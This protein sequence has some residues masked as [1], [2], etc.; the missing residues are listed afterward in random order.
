MALLHLMMAMLLAA[1]PPTPADRYPPPGDCRDD[2][3]VDRCDEVQQAKVRDLFGLG[4]IEDHWRAGD[5]V[6]RAFY[7]DGYGRDVVAITFIRPRGRDPYLSVDF[8]LPNGGDRPAPLTSPLSERDWLAI[9]EASGHFHR[10]LAPLPQ[11]SSDEV[12]ICLHSW[13]YTVEAADPIRDERKAIRRRTEDAC[14]RGLAQAFATY[15]SE[16]AVALLPHCDLLDRRRFRNEETLLSTCVKLKGDRLTAAKVMNIADPIEGASRNSNVALLRP[17][18][19][20]TALIAWEGERHSGKD[21][22]QF[23]TARYSE[24]GHVNMYV[25]EVVGEAQH[26]VRL[27]GSLV[28]YR[29]ENSYESASLEQVWERTG[30]GP[31]QI[32]EAIVGSFRPI[33]RN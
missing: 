2:R 28:R 22:A 27:R 32:R 33:G 31:F 30:E 4:S 20:T 21:A 9:L 25:E 3:G 18:F 14:D 16:R 24:H 7:V 19:H 15:M 23:W 12:V 8:P 5:Q 26:R 17:L 13:V 29:A 6:R 11:R 1:A 10:A